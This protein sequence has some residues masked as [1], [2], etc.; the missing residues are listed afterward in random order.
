METIFEDSDWRIEKTPA[1][2]LVVT[3]KSNCPSPVVSLSA[4][5]E[6][7]IVRS[8]RLTRFCISEILVVGE[9]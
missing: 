2:R 6:G 1:G 3:L 8:M 5:R 7:I 4:G 9:V